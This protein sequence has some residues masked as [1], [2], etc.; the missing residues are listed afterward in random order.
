MKNAVS[1]ELWRW[2]GRFPLPSHV[3]G[4]VH[5]F[6]G[7][8]WPLCG[9]FYITPIHTTPGA[10]VPS[11]YSLISKIIL[12]QLIRTAE[13][14][15]PCGRCGS[16]RTP[17]KPMVA[18]GL[19]DQQRPSAG[20]SRCSMYSAPRLLLA[21]LQ[22]W[23]AKSELGAALAR[24][25]AD[26]EFNVVWLRCASAQSTRLRLGALASEYGR[27]AIIPQIG[28]GSARCFSSLFESFELEI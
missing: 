21:R 7:F 22:A 1:V 11:A 14:K 5:A 26:I 15:F 4:R 28:Y 17:E 13:P 3:P 2:E 9:F 24:C 6:Q 27:P 18:A 25:S 23:P 12:G 8:L 19:R 20:A 10:T 16:L